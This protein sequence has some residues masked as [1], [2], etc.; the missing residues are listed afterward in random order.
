MT[1]TSYARARATRFAG[2]IL[3][4]SMLSS[5][6]VACG[7]TGIPTPPDPAPDAGPM[8]AAD[9]CA[10]LHATCGLVPDGACPGAFCGKCALPQSCG[11]AGK[12]NQCGCLPT[13]CAALGAACGQALDGCDGALSCGI[14][15]PGQICGGAGPNRCGPAPCTPTSCG[16]L[17]AQCGKVSDGCGAILD[18]GGCS[19]PDQCG[20]GGVVHACGCTPVTCAEIGATCGGVSDTCGGTLDCGACTPPETCG[21]AAAHHCGCVPTT[22]AAEGALC[23]SI[24]DRCGG[25]LT[26]GD[27][28]QHSHHD[29][30]SVCVGIGP[31][32]CSEEGQPCQPAT[33]AKLAATCGK[34]NDGCANII[35]CGDCALPATCGGS[36][37]PNHCGCTPKT[38]GGAGAGCGAVADGCGGMLDCGA[39]PGGHPCDPTTHACAM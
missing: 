34:A 7:R 29:H 31:T 24:L 20:G 16:V 5:I 8:C 33:C 15:P 14:C 39:C 4:A 36:G 30:V 10:A 19:A 13:T 28:S 12:A 17:G 26:C 37:I 22:C 35:E 38:C 11:G 3:T 23:G 32:V 9:P 6:A 27:C 18:C 1:L 25:V 2:W 21:A